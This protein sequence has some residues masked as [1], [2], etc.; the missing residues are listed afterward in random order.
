MYIPINIDLTDLVEEFDLSA[1]QIEELGSQLITSISNTYFNA[2]KIK[3]NNK[4]KSAKALYL[5]GLS[6]K[7]IDSLNVEIKLS[8]WLPNIIEEGTKSFDMKE[9]FSKSGKAQI[10]NE[11]SWYL[12]IPF[13]YS[14]PGSNNGKKELPKEI[15]DIVQKQKTPLK[16]EQL[17]QS[18]RLQQ[19]KELA[20]G[21]TYQYKSPI[22]EGLKKDGNDGAISFRRVGEKSDKNSWIYPQTEGKDF[23]SQ[24]ISDI[25][26]E[27]PVIADSLITKFL[28]DLNY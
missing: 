23:F 17:P 22:F 25:E 21:K 1:S 9:G 20:N 8:G 26:N 12:T 3:V 11:G 27:I 15:N 24:A 10:S 4:L 7:K 14:A 2:L 6:M 13:E 18:Q 16:R 5:K 19:L 28:D